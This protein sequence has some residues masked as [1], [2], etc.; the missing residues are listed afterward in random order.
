MQSRNRQ[1]ETSST[2][3]FNRDYLTAV[4]RHYGAW[5]LPSADESGYV[6]GMP[7]PGSRLTLNNPDLEARYGD[8]A[9][10]VCIIN[11]DLMNFQTLIRNVTLELEDI[12]LMRVTRRSWENDE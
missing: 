5:L 3:C 11:P 2:S 10:K 6:E 4:D 1:A 12:I 9:Y 7:T 8:F